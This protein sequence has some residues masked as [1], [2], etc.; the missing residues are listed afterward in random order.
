VYAVLRNEGLGM[1]P[2]LSHHSSNGLC[3]DCCNN[4]DQGSR[5]LA[6]RRTGIFCFPGTVRAD[7]GG[8]Q[9]V[10]SRVLELF[11]FSCSGGFLAASGTFSRLRQVLGK[12]KAN[13]SLLHVASRP[14]AQLQVHHIAH[15]QHLYT[16]RGYLLQCIHRCMGVV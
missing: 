6:Y 4:C 3:S 14:E 5:V 13:F 2:K 10:K 15:S 11:V 12:P 1:A 7:F 8:C 9:Y 16:G